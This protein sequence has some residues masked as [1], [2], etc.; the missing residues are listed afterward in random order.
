MQ[1]EFSVKLLLLA[2][3]IAQDLSKSIIANAKIF[4]SNVIY[5]IILNTF[6]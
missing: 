6:R 4:K 5:F 1:L 3:L 2:V